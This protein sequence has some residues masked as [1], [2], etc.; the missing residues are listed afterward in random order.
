M[1]GIYFHIPFCLK[2]CYYC[3]FISFPNIEKQNEYTQCLIKE[4]QLRKEILKTKEWS[5]IF[6][7]GGT[8]SLL[9]LHNLGK[10]IDE[11]ALYID[12]NK[13]KE[14]TIEV[15]PK[16]LTLEKLQFYK[17]NN[18][19]RI[20][21]GLQTFNLREL[22]VIGRI[23][24]PQ[25]AIETVQIA[26]GQGFDRISVDLIYGLPFQTLETLMAS[27]ETACSLGINHISFYGLQVEENTPL[28][29]MI[30]SKELTIP[31]DEMQENLYLSGVE[32]LIKKGFKQYEVSNFAL[33]NNIALHNYNYWLYKDYLGFG[34]SS[35]SKLANKRFANTDNID[36]YCYKLKGNNLPIKEVEILTY[37]EMEFEQKMLSLRT[38]R[39]LKLDGVKNYDI[40]PELIHNGLA[41]INGDRL[42]LTA[43]GYL[44]SNEIINKL[45]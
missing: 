16:T 10:I 34:V 39:G 23:H 37:E 30:I 5:T 6:F 20:S 19:N 31:N 17:A 29:K 7:G 38:A 28:E 25:D 24:T 32:Y 43:K 36:E 44:I 21:L 26:K 12:F 42:K 3:D 18:I 11:L 35:Y 8:P 14:F 15:N 2:K 4:I 9:S 41:Y 33:G 27:L 45:C 22:K 40:V 1:A 13:I